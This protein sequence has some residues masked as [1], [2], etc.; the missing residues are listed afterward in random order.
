MSEKILVAV[1]G[2]I[3]SVEALKEAE[4]LAAAFQSKLFLVNVQPSFNMIHTK[5][6]ISEKLI[7]EYQ[8]ELFENATK[9][10]VDYLKSKNID[11]EL[12]M[13]IGDPVQQ[14]CKLAKELA[15]THIVIGTRGMGPVKGVVLGS[16]SN[17]ILHEAKVP[18]L[19]VPPQK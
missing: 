12:L 17:G 19:I 3:N 9:P 1:D 15:V 5:L 18:V 16:V 8:Q 4:R 7:K 10:A 11:Y 6:F 2:S 13:R 14:I